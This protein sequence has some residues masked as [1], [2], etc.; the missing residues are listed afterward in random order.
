M[1]TIVNIFHADYPLLPIGGM[2]G[3]DIG[4]LTVKNYYF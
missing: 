1:M 4:G 3:W 2:V